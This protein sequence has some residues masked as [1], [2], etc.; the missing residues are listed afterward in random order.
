MVEEERLDDMLEGVEKEIDL[1]ID[2]LFVDESPEMLSAQPTAP[3]T[4]L[5]ERE[6]KRGEDTSEAVT[7]ETGGADKQIMEGYNEAEAKTQKA[8]PYLHILEPLRHKVRA[9]TEWG[10]TEAALDKVMNGMDEIRK[11][12]TRDDTI[13]KVVEMVTE[14]LTHLREN[15]VLEN[16]DLVNFLLSAFDFIKRLIETPLVQRGPSE[17]K[18]YDEIH[19]RFLNLTSRLMSEI[20]KSDEREAVPR[21]Y[22]KKGEGSPPWLERTDIWET[23][24]H[25]GPTKGSTPQ[26]KTEGGPDTEDEEIINLGL[27]ALATE[28]KESHEEPKFAM[29]DSRVSS[30]VSVETEPDVKRENLPHKNIK[31]AKPPTTIEKKTSIEGLHA[32]TTAFEETLREIKRAFL[33]NMA[34]KDITEKLAIEIAELDNLCERVGEKGGGDSHRRDDVRMLEKIVTEIQED[35]SRLTLILGSESGKDMRIEAVIP[36]VVGKKVIA[37]REASFEAVY[38]ITRE[39]EKQFREKGTVPLKN[40]L[41]PFV[42]LIE[43]YREVS[44]NPD[45]RLVIVKGKGG[46][47]S[48][49]VDRVLKRRYAMM[50][51][52]S[53]PNALGNAKIYR[54]EEMP[55]YEVN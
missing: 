8:D 52:G 3:P 6:Q 1:A 23:S 13:Q 30:P 19:A 18:T 39:Q 32:L 34:L 43:E 2:Q 49:L 35:F 11:A 26:I 51:R 29:G 47:R 17:K 28:S 41:L 7:A 54:S 25:P 36:V 38:S 53:T 21:Q 45:R 37:I 16:G 40:E 46:K 22:K 14:I 12:F 4:R 10:V 9:F 42:D 15:P 24:S 31:G 44:S 5:E 48:L 50:D 33:E 20:G 27:D 55:V